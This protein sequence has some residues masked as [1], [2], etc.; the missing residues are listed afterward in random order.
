[1]AKAMAEDMPQDSS[2]PQETSQD[3]GVIVEVQSSN[4][5]G[6]S[7]AVQSNQN[8][9]APTTQNNQNNKKYD[10]GVLFVHGIGF[11]NP[12]DTFK[13]IFWPVKKRLEELITHKASNGATNLTHLYYGATNNAPLIGVDMEVIDS[14]SRKNIAFRESYWHEANINKK[15]INFLG[16][17]NTIQA[18]LR[19]FFL[20]ILQPRVST[21]IFTIFA[22]FIIRSLSSSYFLSIFEG[23]EINWFI[24]AV[25]FC[26]LALGSI[27]VIAKKIPEI[28]S[29]WRQIQFSKLGY[30]SNYIKVVS[31]DIRLIMNESENIL[32]ISHSMG[33][34]LA[35]K[36]LARIN[37]FKGEICFVGMGSGL[38]PMSIIES[39]RKDGKETVFCGF[40]KELRTNI[41]VYLTLFSL[42]SVELVTL[43]FNLSLFFARRWDN[44]FIFITRGLS[45]TPILMCIFI[46]ISMILLVYLVVHTFLNSGFKIGYLGEETHY[47][48]YYPADLVGNT[49]RFVYSRDINDAR[50]GGILGL[51]VVDNIF[52]RVIFAHDMGYYMKN[53]TVIDSSS[54]L[55]GSGAKIQNFSLRDIEKNLNKNCRKDQLFWIWLIFLGIYGF[56][57]LMDTYKEYNASL[58]FYAIIYSGPMF[59]F[60]EYVSYFIL[61]SVVKTLIHLYCLKVDLNSRLYRAISFLAVDVSMIILMA[62]LLFI[63]IYG[64]PGFLSKLALIMGVIVVLIVLAKLI[65]WVK[66]LAR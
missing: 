2:R 53:N 43:W 26:L 8:S 56:Q 64:R 25:I 18:V 60:L 13:T 46:N 27:I 65:K 24:V 15:G 37:G 34:Y 23:D 59:V 30:A 7:V 40:V 48:F 44:G 31:R 22:G 17:I 36:A 1:M 28:K 19:L 5:T 50:V 16:N 21:I 11:Q 29:L 52:K 35:Y 61:G 57:V 38:G 58:P 32:I 47:E 14:R 9:Q 62:P 12:G 41:L 55:V 63:N 54:C 3:S 10:L 49:S 4:S 6:K 45:G 66:G 39:D 51:S 42:L 20:K 33:G